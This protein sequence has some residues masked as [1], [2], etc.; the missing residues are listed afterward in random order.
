MARLSEAYDERV[1]E[2]ARARRRRDEERMARLLN[3]KLRTIGVDVDFLEQQVEQK[4]RETFLE[5]EAKAEEAAYQA[6]LIR[7][8]EETEAAELEA[9]AKETGDVKATLLK[10]MA[11][12]KNDSTKMIDQVDFES[13]GPASAQAFAGD[14][15]DGADKRRTKMQQEQMKQWCAQQLYERKQ[16]EIDELEE[17]RAYA[18][19]VLAQDEVRGHIARQ[20]AEDTTSMNKAVQQCNK[21]RAEELKL[22]AMIQL[23]DERREA[24]SI[25]AQAQKSS[26]LSEDTSMARSALSPYRF[27]P[28]HFKG[29][30]N[31]VVESIYQGNDSVLSERRSRQMEEQEYENA[32]AN[33]QA[34]V[35]AKMEDAELERQAQVTENEREQAAYLQKQRIELKMK[36]HRMNEEKFGS[37]GENSFFSKFGTSLR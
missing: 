3:S 17:Q 11:V 2:R 25:I 24:E 20:E 37:I 26:F 14:E 23:Q 13:C 19:C 18:E 31:A 4:R 34:D 8:L 21:Q 27:R 10:Q 9:K 1:E 7:H 36:Q 16:R 22:Q 35:I 32:W 30:D 28:D 6:R 29:F 12:P 5:K 15:F 33:H